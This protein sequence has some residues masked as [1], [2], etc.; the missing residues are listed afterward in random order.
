MGGTQD[1]GTF[2][3]SGT[4]NVW[5]QIIYGDGGQSGLN[6]A[7]SELRFNTFTGQANDANFRNG[8]PTEWVI[9]DGPIVVEPGGRR[10]STR[11]SSPTRTRRPRARSSRAR[12]QCGGRRTGADQAYLEANCPEFTTASTT[13]TAVTS[14]RSGR[15]GA[16]DLT[17]RAAY[18]ADRRGGFVAAIE[19]APRTPARCG[20]PRRPAASSSRTT[21]TPRASAVSGRGSI[22]RPPSLRRG[23]RV[24][25]VDPAN[26]NHA[27]ISYSGYNFNT[28][29][30]PGHVFE[31][32]RTGSTATW[33]DLTNNLADLPVTDLVA[34]T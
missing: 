34:T 1:N 28:P 21:P 14:S 17:A 20:P 29:T 27:W 24:I 12:S 15:P 4:P 18:G 8:D 23:S 30:R 2:Q 5:P 33:T 7:N 25:Y 3:Y 11:R 31:V 32:T 19:R 6:A 26:P 16:T 9:I 10:C 22:R 13:R